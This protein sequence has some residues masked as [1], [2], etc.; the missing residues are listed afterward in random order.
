MCITSSTCTHVLYRTAKNSTFTIDTSDL[1]IEANKRPKNATMSTESAD[2]FL[3]LDEEMQKTLQELDARGDSLVDVFEEFSKLHRSFTNVHASEVRYLKRTEELTKDIANV[4]MQMSDMKEEDEARRERKERLQGDI[5]RTWKAVAESNAKESKKKI[6]ISDLKIEIDILKT[7]LQNGSGWTKEQ[8][9]TMNGL[10]ST[11]DDFSDKLDEKRTLLTQTRTSVGALTMHLQNEDEKKSL[12]SNE[13]NDLELR[14]QDKRS[15]TKTQKNRKAKL[16]GELKNRKE[17]CE[18]S[19]RVVKSKNIDIKQGKRD[20]ANMEEKLD[21][22]KKELESYLKEYESVLITTSRL[23]VKL[24]DQIKTNEKNRAQLVSLKKNTDECDFE[25]NLVSKDLKRVKKLIVVSEK[26]SEKFVRDKEKAD[27]KRIKVTAERD[28][29]TVELLAMKHACEKRRKQVDDLL[30]ERDVVTKD[31]SAADDRAQKL[32]ALTKIQLGTQRNLESEING[33]VAQAR[34]L[35][36][37]ILQVNKDV[38]RYKEACSEA[39]KDYFAAV[40]ALKMKE[41]RVNGL[42]KKIANSDSR[43]KQQQNLYEQVRADR[44]MYSKSLIEHQEEIQEMKR[45]FRM[46]NNRIETLKEEITTKDHGLVKEHFEHHKVQREKDVLR[47]EV[48]K[49]KKQITSSEQIIANQFSEITKL[50]KIINEAENERSRQQKEVKSV[51][52]E[53][54]LLGGQLTKRNHELSKLYDSIKLLRSTL[55]RGESQYNQAVAEILGLQNQVDTLQSELESCKGQV[56]STDSMKRE[57]MAIE[58]E[59]TQERMKI[60]FLSEELARPINVHRWRKLESSDPDRWEQVLRIQSLQKTLIKNSE[61]CVKR[62]LLIQEKEKLYVELKNILGRQPGPEVAEQLT[63]YQQNLKAKQRQMKAMTT[64]LEMYKQQVTSSKNDID[65]LNS[66]FASLQ[67]DYIRR[68]SRKTV[69][70]ELGEDANVN[71]DGNE[72]PMSPISVESKGE[73]QDDMYNQVI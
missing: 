57:A 1:G 15:E 10:K 12:L 66:N 2:E 18:E 38:E 37:K 5:E 9:N 63:L 26:K 65:D 40:E 34:L 16:D 8:Q 51:A 19:A 29:V 52:S 47:N 27:A 53:K 43:L 24:Q 48:N 56:T 39:N 11:K 50:N 42:N 21:L 44:N 30:R 7:G 13:V 46:M 64:E 58:N 59:L 70:V 35:Q 41:Q 23:T 33:Y 60:K 69:K 31:A 71:S 4:Q 61:K 67:Q 17:S 54:D 62:D 22:A 49:V 14:V 20:L 3:K 68:M 73:K 25:C 72:L 36:E 28:A 32:V 55:S 6:R 45:N